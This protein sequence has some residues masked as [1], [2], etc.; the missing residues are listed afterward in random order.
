MKNNFAEEYRKEQ[1]IRARYDAADSE[2]GKNDAR[3]EHRAWA[4]EVD[5]KG[6]GYARCFRSYR[7]ARDRDNEYIDIS[8][9]SDYRN[10]AELVETLRKVGITHFTFSSTWSGA[11]ESAWEFQK[12][13]CTLEGLVEINSQHR[14]YLTGEYEKRHGY[15]FRVN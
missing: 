12:A 6:A 7:E 2:A 10:E 13:G 4:T 1:E 11:V 14:D 5:A 3:E 15:L 8:E 9:V